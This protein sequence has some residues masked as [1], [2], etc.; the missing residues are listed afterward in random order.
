MK[1]LNKIGEELFSKLRGRFKNI[2]IGNEEG[3][4]TN[5]PAESRFYEFTYGDQGGKVSVSLDEDSVVV[6]YSEDLFDSN[7]ASMKT[8]WYDFLKEMRVFA[9]KRMLNF[10]VRDIQKSNLEKRDYKFLSNKNGDNTMTESTMYGT[11]KTSYQNIADARICVKHSENINQE[12]A[13]GRSQKIGSIYIESANGERFKYPYK[14]LNG[15]RAM[16]MHVAEGGNM[17]DDFGK[18]IVGLSEEMNKLRKFKTYMSRSSVMAEG[19]ADYMDVV[20]ERIDTVKNTVAKLQNKK[21]YKEATDNFQSVVLEEVPE[22]VAT[23]WTAQL[24]IKQF[25]EELKSVFPY[26]YKL[27]SEANK[28]KEL[29]PEDLLGE[30]L[31]DKEDYMA[32]KKALQDIQ[33]N[34]NTHKDK[35]LTKELMRKKAELD[36]QGKSAGYK[37]A[38]SMGMNKYGLAAEKKGDKFISYR[39]GEKTGEFDSMEEL[40]KHQHDLIA[41]ESTIPTEADIDAGFEN[42]M[43]QFAEK[44]KP[45]YI[46]IDNDGDEEEPMTKAI[47]DKENDDDEEA[48]EGN[49]FAH[50]VR[51]AKMDGKKKGDKIDHPDDDEE[52]ITLEKEQKM[53]LPE[54]ILSLFDRETGAFP[55]GETAVLTMVEK[56]YGENFIEPAKQFIEK[57]MQKYEDVITGPAV[58]EMEAEHEPEKVTLA[59]TADINALKRAAGIEETKRT[60]STNKDLLNIKALAGL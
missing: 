15:A 5:M 49:A 37:E 40:S 19:L 59:V 56:D 13:G 26:I 36:D 24:T 35:K 23:D 51:K 54:K 8:K 57:I 45:D 50:A 28:V 16:A 42:M 3:I 17:Y 39:N 1:D 30:E 38:D 48:E 14:H 44:S 46:D 12:L 18:H 34:P 20:N 60:V 31:K 55:K 47:D 52:D 33:M 41:D 25:N 10:E 4:T 27:V 6:M 2:T 21:Y 7:N 53:P 32:K 11:S 58:Q 29:G 22:D 9:K 43:G